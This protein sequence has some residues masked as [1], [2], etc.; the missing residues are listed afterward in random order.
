[1]M[2]C[3]SMGIRSSIAGRYLASEAREHF[4]AQGVSSA[5]VLLQLPEQLAC[6]DPD[7]ILPNVPDRTSDPFLR[8]DEMMWR[9]AGAVGPPPKEKKD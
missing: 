3:D 8:L 5:R 7:D 4:L 2:S 1:M 6:G 9:G